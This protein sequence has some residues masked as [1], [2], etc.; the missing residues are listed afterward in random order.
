MDHQLGAIVAHDRDDLE[1]VGTPG[2]AEVETGV[3]VLVVDGKRV[4]MA[5]SMSSSAIPCL[6]ADEWIS[7]ME[8]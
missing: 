1:Q 2:R 3:V 7:T 5:C 8:L 6:R 4:T